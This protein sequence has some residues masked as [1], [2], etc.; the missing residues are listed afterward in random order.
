MFFV[1]LKNIVMFDLVIVMKR[2]YQNFDKDI[3]CQRPQQ[4]FL[5][6]I[7]MFDTDIATR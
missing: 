2:S 5:K 1:F 3:P 4:F 6:K 7:L